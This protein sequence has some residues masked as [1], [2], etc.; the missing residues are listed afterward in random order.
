[1][2][3]F[4]NF[5]GFRIIMPAF[6][7]DAAGLL[8]TSMRSRGVTIMFEPKFLYNHPM[9]QASKTGPNHFV[10]FGKAR[11]RRP[12][13]DLTIV[14]YGNAVHWSLKAA[15]R[16]AEEGYDAEVVDLRS[17]VPYDMET[18]RASV[19]KTNRVIVASEDHKTGGFGGEVLAS[20]SEEC[21]TFLDAPPRRVCT[22]DTPIGFS[23]ILEAA[24][25]ISE[26]DIYQAA[27]EVLK[28]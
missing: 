9:A 1:E 26:E 6:A 27:Q 24:T 13:K 21:F 20:V 3:V 28:Y 23:R 7:D 19:Q 5:P 14:T 18:V 10:P 4:A 25:L 17:L 11:I 22:K 12:G 2:G 16:L 8:R 15:E